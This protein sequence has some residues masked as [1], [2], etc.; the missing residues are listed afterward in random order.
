MRN[1]RFELDAQ[2]RVAHGLPAA[3]AHISFATDGATGFDG[4][5]NVYRALQKR[6]LPAYA[7]LMMT[8]RNAGWLARAAWTRYVRKRVL[9]P[10]AARFEVHIVT[11]Q[12]PTATNRITL[13]SGDNDPF[14][15]PL[16]QIHWEVS[17]EDVGNTEAV[18]NTFSHYWSRTSLAALGALQPYGRDQWSVTLRSGGGI[19]HPGGSLRMGTSADTA[20]VD[21]DLRAFGVP[22]LRVVST[23][24]FPTGGSANPTMMLALMGLRLTDALRRELA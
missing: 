22:N 11:E 3:F 24:T 23:A 9:L 1:T 14:G 17:K 5:R 16:A 15:V 18:L 21:R 20:V 13:S 10:A 19:Y 6:Q 7:D 2:A 12:E 4:L 8:A